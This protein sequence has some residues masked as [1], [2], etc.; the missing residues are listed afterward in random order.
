MSNREEPNGSYYSARYAERKMAER[1][2]RYARA[3]IEDPC[4]R[5]GHVVPAKEMHALCSVCRDRFRTIA[6]ENG[7]DAAEEWIK[8]GK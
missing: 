6:R 7:L 3:R 5:C 1:R 4:R 2:G 8:K